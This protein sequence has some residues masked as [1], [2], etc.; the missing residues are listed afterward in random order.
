MKKMVGV[1]ILT[2]VWATVALSQEKWESPSLNIGDKWKYR[3]KSGGE[4][5]QEVTAIENDVYVI[6]Y[7]KE[8]RTYDKSTMNFNSVMEEG[9]RFK[10]TGSRS[11][12]LNFPMHI[13]K[14]WKNQFSSQPKTGGSRRVEK[15]YLE[16][17]FASGFEEV[18]V[19]G[20]TF[21]AIKIEYQ[22]TELGN[23]KQTAKGAYWYSP[24][25]KAIIK[26]VEQIS[27]ET[28]GMELISHELK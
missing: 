12:I 20:G 26:R 28:L 3:D 25:V 17:Y 18:S 7:G 9:K 2:M 14:Q 10:F 13:G 15:N 22:Q 23:M 6:R 27:R 8:T 21:K 24:E 1:C 5:T 4:W 11:K 16:E 19:L